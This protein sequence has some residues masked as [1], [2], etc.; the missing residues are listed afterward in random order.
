MTVCAAAPFRRLRPK[1]KS[2]NAGHCPFETRGPPQRVRCPKRT[3]W[4]S[5][6]R[7]QSRLPSQPQISMAHSLK[8]PGRKLI[9]MATK[10]KMSPQLLGLSP[11]ASAA[12]APNEIGCRW[13]TTAGAP[14][15]PWTNCCTRATGCPTTGTLPSRWS[16]STTPHSTGRSASCQRRI[17]TVDEVAIDVNAVCVQRHSGKPQPV[18]RSARSIQRSC[19]PMRNQSTKN[20]QW[21]EGPCNWL[22]G[23]E[24]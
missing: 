12:R 2:S 3:A 11:M 9:C 8:M 13:W 17:A 4:H 16:A 24:D 20:G 15:A 7:W 23:A 10:P 6:H 14:S 1:P 19:P 21:N 5:T 22:I 18:N